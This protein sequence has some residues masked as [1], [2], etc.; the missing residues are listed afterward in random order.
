MQAD[1]A[2]SDVQDL[3]ARLRKLRT[4]RRKKI[5]LIRINRIARS[6]L[7]RSS[8]EK[9]LKATNGRCHICGGA[10]EA[11]IGT[12]TM[13]SPMLTVARTRWTTT[14]LHILCVTAIGGAL[15]T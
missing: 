11:T 5:K 1:E 12:R 8:R 3:A 9:V 6:G 7:S 13:C 4:R 14:C 2:F 15:V 10:L